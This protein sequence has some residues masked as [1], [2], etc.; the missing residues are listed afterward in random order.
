[1]IIDIQSQRYKENKNKERNLQ[2]NS[3]FG[4]ELLALTIKNKYIYFVLLSFFRNFAPW[5]DNQT[6]WI[7]NKP[8]WNWAPNPWDGC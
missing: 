1:M 4:L 6:E 3:N 7:I 5:K 8:H 2:K